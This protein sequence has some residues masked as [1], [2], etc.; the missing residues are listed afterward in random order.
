MKFT[1]E[2]L[3]ERLK[4]VDLW[5]KYVL[6]HDDRDWSHQQNVIINSGLRSS[7]LTKEQF[8]NMKSQGRQI[9]PTPRRA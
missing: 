2:N 5:S 7:T 8:L 4:F 3:K 1:D 9:P 6:E